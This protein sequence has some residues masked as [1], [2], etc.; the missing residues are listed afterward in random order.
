MEHIRMK[1]GTKNPAALLSRSVAGVLGRGLVY[2]LPGSVRAVEEYMSEI[3]RSLE[4]LVL[5]LHG[6]DTHGHHTVMHSSVPQEGEAP[7]EPPV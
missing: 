3:L 1:Y 2:T 5:M 6:L 4:H 7:A